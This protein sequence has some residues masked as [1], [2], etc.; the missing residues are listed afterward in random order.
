M[1]W[2]RGSCHSCRPWALL[3]GSVG[4]FFAAGCLAAAT[5]SNWTFNAD[6]TLKESFDS[7][8]YLQDTKPNPTIPNAAQPFQQSL[9]TAVTP[10]V[11]FAFKPGPQF[12]VAGSYAP[13]VVT[14]HAEPT[15]SHV[16]HRLGL[17]FN[18]RLDKVVWQMQNTFTYID[19]S[20]EG[21]TFGALG[22]APAIGGIPIR[23][24]REALIYRNS[25]GAF[26]QHGDWFF[27][28]AVSS[29]I[30]DFRTELRDPVTNPFYQNYV[31]R[32]DFNL[33][34]DGGYQ[35]VKDGH[36]FLGYRYGWQHE[37]P[38][39][40]RDVDY[41]N[42]YNRALL[43]FEGRLCDTL[44]MN[45]F[46]GPDWRDYAHHTPVGFKDHQIKLY[47]DGSVVF[48]PTK[49]DTVTLTLKRFE[50][51][52]FGTPS[53]YED[54]TYEI[55]AR[56]QFNDRFYAGAGFKAYGGDW[57]PPVRRDDWIFTTSASAGCTLA[58]HFSAELVYTYDWADSLVPNTP[59][60][61]FTRHLV[62][63]SAKYSF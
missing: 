54:I 51:P 30:H 52:A 32:N 34:V 56:H 55:A 11:G 43:G 10:K 26:H 50:Q 4:S 14:Y 19:G 44:K 58:P 29:Y 31:D 40:N 25:F 41:S 23:D 37:P 6:L 49:A 33:G 8:V 45:L 12:N 20:K 9:V 53:A 60:R 62:A 59:G 5:T 3:L 39:P 13:E 17:L 42:F 47:L 2:Q 36:L 63:L 1:Y 16:A 28:P 48:T 27:R 7:N 22:G 18:G 61:E 57:E 35:I 15:E 24:R 46:I 38:L 21:L